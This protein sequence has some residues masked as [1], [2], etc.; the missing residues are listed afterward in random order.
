MTDVLQRLFAEREEKY[1]QFS[2]SLIPAVDPERVIGVRTPK[3]RQLAKELIKNGE[4]EEFIKALPH[5]YFEEDNL[6]AY[7]LCELKDRQRLFSELDRFLP[8]VDNWATCDGLRPR[9]FIKDRTGLEEKTEEWMAAD[10]VY[11]RRFGIEML[12]C[13]FLGDG[14]RPEQAERVAATD[15]KEYYL[16]MMV[17]WYFAT[18][19]IDR[20]ETALPYLTENRL[21]KATHNRTI[22]KAVES[23]RIGPEQKERLKALR[24]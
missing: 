8:Y 16:S 1:R 2:L 22:Q 11:V 23:F 12:M 5:K 15:T 18:A 10:G 3:L 4:W 9:L 7:I 14:F 17:A 20:S 24:R 6:H 21:D 19:L 13:H